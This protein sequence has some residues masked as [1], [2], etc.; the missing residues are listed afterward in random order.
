MIS[1]ENY[2]QIELLCLYR[3]PVE[4]R[5]RSGDMVSGVALDTARN[6]A[7]EECLKLGVDAGL[8]LVVLNEIAYVRV[9]VENPH[10]RDIH[11]R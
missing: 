8:R 3:Y 10:L 5:L 2:D 9:C 6:D 11:F 4:V 1:C 7:R